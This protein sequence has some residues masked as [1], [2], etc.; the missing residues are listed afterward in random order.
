MRAPLHTATRAEL[1]A[2]GLIFIT[3]TI[4]SWIDPHDR[5][6]WWLEAL[7]ALVAAAMLSATWTR[8]PL[9]RLAY[10]LILIHAIILL[11]G[12][13][14]TYAEV[15]LFNQL[16]D[17]MGADR[18]S[19][20]GLGHLAQGFVPAIIGR[21]L[22]IRTSPLHAGKWLFILVTLSVLGISAI[23]ELIEWAAAIS[24]G[25][26]A[27]A[28][29]GTQGDPWDTQKDMALALAGATISQ[30]MLVKMHQRQLGASEAVQFNY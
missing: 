3:I 7:P 25:G 5:L 9:T 23:Y 27:D 14:Y 17:A 8:F 26:A 10:W 6:T 16:R 24:S 13:H 11:V 4:W 12:A 2:I 22:L 21:E 15:P 30:L 29:L 18:N 28:F 19:Y 20:D 1:A